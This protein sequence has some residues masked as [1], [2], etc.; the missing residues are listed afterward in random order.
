MNWRV[1]QNF[2]AWKLPKTKHLSFSTPNSITSKC[3][4]NTIMS[5]SIPSQSIIKYQSHQILSHHISSSSI[6]HLTISQHEPD[7]VCKDTTILR[8][9]G[10]S[11][12]LISHHIP[13]ITSHHILQSHKI[14]QHTKSYITSY[15]TMSYNH[16]IILQ[17]HHVL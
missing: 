4:I 8:N 9:E 5:H 11:N 16:I 1:S 7:M 10:W 17:S 15:P 2:T 13:P 3:S 12:I 14:L 6:F